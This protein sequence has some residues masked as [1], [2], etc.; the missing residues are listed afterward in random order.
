MANDIDIKLFHSGVKDLLKSPEIQAVLRKEADAI[1]ARAGDG[2]EVDE[3][4]GRNR[5]RASVQTDGSAA[6]RRE[7]RDHNLIRAL[8]SSRG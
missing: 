8:G 4:V 6:A 3:Y 5:A 1:A 2:Y 7:A